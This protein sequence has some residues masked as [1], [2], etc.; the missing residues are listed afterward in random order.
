MI[1]SIINF[2]VAS[3]FTESL[4]ILRKRRIFVNLKLG[5]KLSLVLILPR[6]NQ[7]LA[8]TVKKYIKAFLYMF[9]YPVGLDF[10]TLFQV[11]C[12]RLYEGTSVWSCLCLICYKALFWYFSKLQSFSSISIKK[13]KQLSWARV[14]NL[15][16]FRAKNSFC[17]N[18][19]A[20][21]SRNVG[22]RA[23]KC[24][25]IVLNSFERLAQILKVMPSSNSNSLNSNQVHASKKF[26]F[27]IW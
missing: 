5:W 27:L 22:K 16:S 10:L 24:L 20:V 18:F 19:Y 13:I 2:Q 17:F 21:I 15:I 11:F 14:L 6:G 3:K 7:T 25:T 8:I 1:F 4:R 23:P 12:P 26:L 9:F